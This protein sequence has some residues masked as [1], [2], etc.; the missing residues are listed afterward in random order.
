MSNPTGDDE[1]V[2]YSSVT[3]N[4]D[5]V[6]S[7]VVRTYLSTLNSREESTATGTTAA[8]AVTDITTNRRTS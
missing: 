7:P 5:V 6:A 4:I 3:S 8:V 1:G 2:L